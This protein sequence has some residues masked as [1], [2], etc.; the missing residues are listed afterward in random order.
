MRSEPEIMPE[1]V[2]VLGAGSWGATLAH[3]LAEK[4]I[5]VRLW[6][7][8][9]DHAGRLTRERTLPGKLEGFTLSN[10]VEVNH[11]LPALLEGVTTLVFATPSRHVRDAAARVKREWGPGTEHL[12][13]VSASKGIEYET[14]KPMSVLISEELG[15]THPVS[16]SGPSHAEEVC[17]SLPTT[18]VAASHDQDMAKRVQGLF[19]TPRFRVYTSS[20]LLGVE[21]GGSLKNLV[22]IAAGA[23]AGMGFGDNTMAALV[24]RGLAEM[25]RLGVAMG[26]DPLT[27]AGLSG[28]GDLVV[29]CASRHSRN[30]RLGFALAQGKTLSQA[31]E[32]I[33]MEVE[34]VQMARSA[35]SLAAK[36][37]VDMPIAGQVAETLFEGIPVEEAVRALMLRDPKPELGE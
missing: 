7:H 21:L 5:L 1:R 13:A 14:L 8:R 11:C 28:L 37:G 12:C 32:E 23:A 27:F 19:L 10:R 31:L 25:T 20:D 16:L 33:G 36:W 3:L 18:V 9:E 4:G 17:R 26:A 35:K 15:I 34:G 30:R 29:T 22:A 2:L 24:T 6:S